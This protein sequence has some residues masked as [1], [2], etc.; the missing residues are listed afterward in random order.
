MSPDFLQDGNTALIAAAKWGHRS[1]IELLLSRGACVEA[2][3]NYLQ[4]GKA[5]QLPSKISEIFEAALRSRSKLYE[6]AAAGEEELV[7]Q[8][9]DTGTS[10]DGHKVEL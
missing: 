6:A 9:L 3:D 8:L 4:D 7:Q 2:K 5:V 1:T 10:V